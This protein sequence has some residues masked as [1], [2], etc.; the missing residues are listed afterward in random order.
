[1]VSPDGASMTATTFG[2]DAQL[3]QF[4]QQTVWDRR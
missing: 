2:Y 4:K 3:R 1:V